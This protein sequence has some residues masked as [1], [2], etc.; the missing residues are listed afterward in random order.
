MSA[1][2]GSHMIAWQGIHFAI[3]PDWRPL[4]IEGSHEKGSITV[5]DI[6]VPIFQLRWLRPPRDYDSAG[7]IRKRREE[8]SG[9]QES[10]RPPH[11]KAFNEVSW[12]KDLAIRQESE[13]TVWWGYSSKENLL[14]EILMTN[15]ADPKTSRWFIERSLPKL[16]IYGKDQDSI[17][18]IYSSRFSVPAGFTLKRKELAAGSITL[19]FKNNDKILNLRQVFPAKLA[20]E[21]RSLI[22][23]LW[24]PV[25]KNHW[26]CY[27]MITENKSSTHYHWQG[28]RKLPFPVGWIF[29]KQ[30]EGKIIHDADLDRLLM[31]ELLWQGPQTSIAMDGL[32]SGMQEGRN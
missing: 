30:C 28:T 26:R 5:G 14:V 7:W 17:W 32:I 18:Q 15:L 27:N 10:A 4:R 3:Q 13:K 16:G 11:P 24:N 31:A 12:I 6:E 2:T 25:F 9:G 23:W 29:P 20:V 19:Q 21:R 1:A 22:A 8:T